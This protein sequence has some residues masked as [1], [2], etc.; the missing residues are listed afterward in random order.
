MLPWA[1]YPAETR[2]AIEPSYKAAAA[3]PLDADAAGTLARTL[4]A[5]RELEAAHHAYRRAQALAP[6]AFAWAYLDGIVL[7]QLARHADAAA[8]LRRALLAAPGYLP[9]RV[10]LA[11]SLL[12]SGQIDESAPQYEALLAEPPVEPFARFGLGRIAAI[13]ERHGQAIAHLQRAVEL[14]PE[15][16]EAYYA[17]AMSFA[18]LQ[19]R[20]DAAAALQ[21]HTRFRITVPRLED[22]VLAATTSL[23]DDAVTSLVRGVRLKASGDLAGAIEAHEAAVRR[24]PAYALAHANLISLYSDAA[25]WTQVEE[26]YRAVVSLG[27]GLADANFDYGVAHE[28]QGQ[29]DLAEAAYRRAL[30]IN[31]EHTAARVN[32]G[33]A[34]ERRKD[35]EGAAAEFRRAIQSRPTDRLAHYDLARML[36][37]L[38]HPREAVSRFERALDAAH[39][40]APAVL[41]GLA[42]AHALAG[43]PEVA[44][45][46]FTEAR[47]SAARF[48]RPD[49]LRAIDAAR[50]SVAKGSR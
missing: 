26:H 16:G 12:K 36:V 10:R 13:Q 20:D 9:A 34:L 28:R 30:A 19:R 11:E 15:W 33:R 23:R 41:L 49:M 8:Q 1:A 17:L 3:R 50:A 38:G 14:F 32:L 40:T 27:F 31:V 47:A 2:A 37:V 25:N 22:P 46:R 5:W 29:W 44:E 48:E 4:H 21:A 39:P 43:Q 6:A 7:Q 45:A 18:A 24:E 42:V 35:F